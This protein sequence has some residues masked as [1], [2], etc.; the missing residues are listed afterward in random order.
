M[1][2]IDLQWDPREQ[3]TEVVDVFENLTLSDKK[4]LFCDMPVGTGKSYAIVMM[5]HKYRELMGEDIKFDVLTNTKIL[6]EQYLRDFDFMDSVKGIDNY[7]C[8][9]FSCS[10]AEGMDLAKAKKQKCMPCSYKVARKAYENSSMGVLNFHLFI[11]YWTYSAEMM[12]ERDAKVLFID[13]AH[14]FEEIYSNFVDAFVSRKY[15]EDL[16]IWNESWLES[17]LEV[18]TVRHLGVFLAESVLPAITKKMEE[19]QK[20][21]TGGQQNDWDKINLIRE[22]KKLSR[23]KCK[24]GRL[25]RDEAEWG[26]NWVINIDKTKE[27]WTWKAEVVWSTKYL[28]ELWDEYDKVIFLSGSFLDK[29]FAINLLGCKDSESEY[30]VMDSPFPLEN[31]PVI[32]DPVDN[33]SYDKKLIAFKKMVPVI[34]DILEEHKDSK[35]IIHT[36]NYELA[37]WIQEEFEEEPRLLFHDSKTREA[38]LQNHCNSDVPTV[39]VSP[40]M[41]NGIDLKGDLSRFQVILKVPYP[42]L[43]SKKVKRKMDTNKKWYSWKT[44]CDVIQACGRSVRSMDDY[45]VTYILDANFLRLLE[46][47]RLPRYIKDA[48]INPNK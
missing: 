40:S 22:S 34:A 20:I 7:R 33:M 17:L 4:F 9:K 39:L 13:E 23:A 47:V 19:I 30:V 43:G 45:A 35:G 38:T 31:R 46:R 3:Q 24:Y 37:R 18:K 42:H 44:M 16:D 41:I 8:H 2:E 6:Q 11:S 5:A 32:I 14:S 26:T 29:K 36:A 1:R 15:F 25:L 12:K 27:D 28:K 21:V 48:I 10:C